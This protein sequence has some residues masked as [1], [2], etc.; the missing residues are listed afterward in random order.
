MIH[1]KLQG[2]VLLFI[3]LWLAATRALIGAIQ[4]APSVFHYVDFEKSSIDARTKWGVWSPHDKEWFKSWKTHW[5]LFHPGKVSP[6]P[7]PIIPKIIHQIWLGSPVPKRYKQWRDSWIKHHPGWIYM[8]WT[9]EEVKSLHLTNRALYETA[10]NYGAKGDILQCELLYQFGGLYVDTDFECLKPFDEFH[11][12]YSFY[13]SVSKAI[14]M[15]LATGL[16][17]S[18]PG[19]PILRKCIEQLGKGANPHDPIGGVGPGFFTRTMMTCFDINDPL[20]M[21]F[22]GSYFYP[23]SWMDHGS[24]RAIEAA[25]H[26]PESYAFHH[27]EGA[28]KAGKWQDGLDHTFVAQEFQNKGKVS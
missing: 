12:K 15:E 3:T 26:R 19:H 25:Y 9:D 10:T 8:L 22:P 21:I 5:D 7:Q 14:N 24:F 17:A 16:V 11:H 6:Q 27:W 13:T 4:V 28:W 20:V 2:C 23:L 18:A 1:S